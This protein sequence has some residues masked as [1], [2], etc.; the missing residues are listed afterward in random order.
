[1]G[2]SLWVALTVISAAIL[3]TKQLAG[4]NLITAALARF[5]ALGFLAAGVIGADGWI[6][7]WM[8]DVIS[9]ATHT[10]QH[11]ST[12]AFGSALLIGVVALIASILFLL[13]LLPDS[14]W[15]GSMPDWGSVCGLVIPALAVS[16]PG[17]AG[18]WLRNDVFPALAAPMID[19]VRSWL[20]M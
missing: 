15:G 5:A 14:W 9:W 12:S 1:M 17:P 8:H 7:R 3:V 16:I 10:G 19:T 4:H 13:A 2:A 20:G 11:A 18:N 6:G